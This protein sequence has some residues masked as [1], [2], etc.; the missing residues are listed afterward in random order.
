MWSIVLHRRVS[1]FLG[2][3]Q[4]GSS[5]IDTGLLHYILTNEV[6]HMTNKIS[7]GRTTLLAPLFGSP[8]REWILLYIM[9][10]GEAYARELAAELGFALRAVQ[11]QLAMLEEGGVV[12]SRMR[13]RTRLYSLNP[14]YPFQR[15]L[16]ALLEKV[17]RAL[18]D[19]ERDRLYTPRL[20]PR[21]S[22]KPLRL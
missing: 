9:T 13:G 8:L 4:T 22:G 17:L 12:Y 3:Y 1:T 18:P 2:G 19:D 11:R 5:T 6:S 15:E 7:P 21:R 10:R 14:R 16:G 20:R